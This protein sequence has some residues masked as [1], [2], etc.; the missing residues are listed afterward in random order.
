MRIIDHLQNSLASRNRAWHRLKTCLLAASLLIIT[1]VYALDGEGWG[2]IIKGVTEVLHN[3]QQQEIKQREE[4]QRLEQQRLQEQQQTQQLAQQN[5]QQTN[6][7]GSSQSCKLIDKYSG[8][9]NLEWKGACKNGLVD[10]VGVA[11]YEFTNINKGTPILEKLI[12]KFNEGDIEGLCYRTSL[13]DFFDTDWVAG[14]IVYFVKDGPIEVI[15]PIN[16]YKPKNNV[17]DFSVLPWYDNNTVVNNTASEITYKQAMS[18]VQ[19][20]MSNKSGSSMDVET[21]K[22]YL[23]GRLSFDAT[24]TQTATQQT[25]SSPS[26][27]SAGEA[28]DEPPQKGIFLDRRKKATKK[29]K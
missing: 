9:K 25:S 20:F 18:L 27:E 23:E 2:A 11:I 16:Y 17:R 7:A 28:T 26:A 4:Q 15:G 29:K 10:G 21:L 8:L 19:K 13:N 3:N 24:Q 22:A 6:N 14:Y 1:P 12:C 5:L